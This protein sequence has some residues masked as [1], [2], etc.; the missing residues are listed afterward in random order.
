MNEEE[1]S[2]KTASWIISLLLVIFPPAAF[3]LLWKD[4]AYHG[5]FAHLSWFFGASLVLFGVSFNFYVLPQ[6]NL[7]IG[8]L[9][10]ETAAHVGSGLLWLTVVLGIVQTGFGFSLRKKFRETGELPAVYLSA[11]ILLF[12]LDYVLPLLVYSKVITP[13]YSSLIS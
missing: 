7:A 6:I 8:T 1:K 12:I 9:T 13:L 11:S 2:P 4:R 5:W 10:G 3:Y